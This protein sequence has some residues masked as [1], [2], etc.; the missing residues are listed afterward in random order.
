LSFLSR[1]TKSAESIQFPQVL[2]EQARDERYAEWIRNHR[3]N[4]RTERW[5]NEQIQKF[6]YRPTVGILMECYNPNESFLRESLASIF[7]QIYPFCELSII[8]RGSENP[9]VRKILDE[10]QSESRTKISFQRGEQRDVEAIAKIMKRASAE[11][12][13]LMN[14][15]DVLEPNALFNMVASLQNTVEIDFVFSDS[16]L[17]DD[18]GMR[19]LPQFKPVWAVGAHYPLGYY[20]HPVLLHDRLV[21]KLKGH[22]KIS[23]LMLEGT[24]LDDASNHSRYVVQAPGVLY[25][26]R[27]RGRK[28]ETPPE[29]VDN[30]LMNENLVV[31]N[32]KIQINPLLRAR[33][34]PKTPL[35]VLWA[36]DSLDRDDGPAVW[37]HLV[38][39]LSKESG[40]RFSI[41]SLNDGPMRENYEK[42]APVHIASGQEQMSET[43]SRLHAEQKFD[44]A[45][46]SSVDH[47]WFPEILQQ[48]N[49]PTLWQLYPGGATQDVETLR[50]KFQ[51]PATILF[52]NAESA[53]AYA[54]LAERDVSRVLPTGVDLADLKT[55]KQRNS[56]FDLRAKF[57][58]SNSA[59]IFSICGPTIPR[60][61]QKLFAQAAIEVLKMNQEADLHFIIAGEQ[62]GKYLDEI[63]AVIDASGFQG[64]FLFIPQTSDVFQYYPVYLMSDVCVSCSTEEV[65]PLALLEGMAMKKA[66]VATRVISNIAVVEEEEN[67]Y[68]VESGNLM[69]MTE[70]FDL[71]VKG[72]EL[73]DFFG[74]RSLEII[75]EKFHYRKIATRFEDLLRETIVYE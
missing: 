16:D 36:I 64:H 21:K 66:I 55:F 25:H 54:Q 69:Q 41:V 1:S 27:Q 42:H 39:F 60:K 32:G 22:E 44:V 59:A 43:I 26:G 74:R 58:I 63:K 67:G 57:H 70:A 3:W 19:I 28:N 34:E 20:Q 40:H 12:I 50:K 31:E 17:L 7:Q 2:K 38:R 49:L 8:D 68:L 71:L 65:F 10:V 37:Y 11:W 73:R 5:C 75:Y 51:F 72:P 14:A 4:F 33:S 35:R 47:I 23:L 52:L 45:F 13:L 18:E 46:V 24:L 62:P 6:T 53:A 9:A 29:P 56:P 15:E 30:V 61:G 48:I